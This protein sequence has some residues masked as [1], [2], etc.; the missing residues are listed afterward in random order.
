MLFSC[1][2]IIL[3]FTNIVIILQYIA[4]PSNAMKMVQPYWNDSHSEARRSDTEW[5]MWFQS[6]KSMS[7]NIQ[8]PFL[9]G[10][11]TQ[12]IV[13]TET[14]GE[15]LDDIGAHDSQES[16]ASLEE[17]K[18]SARGSRGGGRWLRKRGQRGRGL[19]R[20][21]PSSSRGRGSSVT[22]GRG[23]SATRGRGRSPRGTGASGARGRPVSASEGSPQKSGTFSFYK[24]GRVGYSRTR[25]RSG[26]GKGFSG[27]ASIAE[28]VKTS[29]RHQAAV[30]NTGTS[31]SKPK[32]GTRGVRGSRS[33]RTRGRG[34]GRGR[35][36]QVQT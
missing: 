7:D 10:D 20:G 25:T 11:M 26:R 28:A 33:G 17:K 22:R 36:G 21:R 31:T 14:V 12:T 18:K 19:A 27:A 29:D 24:R 23:S 6:Y 1:G 32:R 35:R 8:P 34:R 2:I 13:Q 3:H 16:D 5:A 30:S 15:S 9:G 4:P